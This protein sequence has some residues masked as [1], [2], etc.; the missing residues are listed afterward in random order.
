LILNY[1]A[2]PLSAL[3]VS[4]NEV[5]IEWCVEQQCCIRVVRGWGAVTTAASKDV[6]IG[7]A[8]QV[9]MQEGVSDVSKYRRS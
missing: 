6:G 2:P 4:S 9:H 5:T 3:E 1:L 8:L 7:R